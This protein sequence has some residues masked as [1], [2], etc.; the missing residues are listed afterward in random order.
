M[1]HCQNSLETVMNRHVD[2][3]EQCLWSTA[4]LEALAEGMFVPSYGMKTVNETTLTV[5][6]TQTG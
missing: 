5:N 1:F 4:S 3:K 2:I 6:T